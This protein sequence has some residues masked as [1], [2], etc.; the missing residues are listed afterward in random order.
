MTHLR[1][2]IVML[3]S[4]T[5]PLQLRSLGLIARL[6]EDWSPPAGVRMRPY[7][8]QRWGRVCLALQIS[9]PP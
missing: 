5:P 4:E 8:T 3:N 7:R 9:R 2:Q 6:H 1:V